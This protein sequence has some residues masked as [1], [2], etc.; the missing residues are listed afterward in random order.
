MI[1]ANP[2]IFKNIPALVWGKES[3][4]VYIYAHGKLSRKEY[5]RDFAV[6][7]QKKGCQTLSFDLPCH[8]ERAG[9]RE[10]CDICTGMR[11]L[12]DIYQRASRRW[13]HLRL[14][15]CSIGAFF[16]LHA[17]A[18]FPF[19]KALFQSPIVDMEQLIQKMMVWSGVTEEELQQRQEILTPI[20]TLSWKDYSYVRE[21][22]VE[23]WTIPTQVLY[24]GKDGLQSRQ[25]VQAFCDRF[26]CGLTV[27]ES[28]EHAFL[29]EGDATIARVWLQQKM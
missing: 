15:G 11:D 16:S 18:G 10:K 3:D 17:Y 21:H 13:P 23:N 4:T 22:P 6:I 27:A 1:S 19:E 24:G 29:G 25:A 26:H 9:R 14:F 5:A 2:M 28:S 20:D 7:A 12:E 8:G